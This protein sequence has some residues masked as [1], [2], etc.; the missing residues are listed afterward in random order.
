[1]SAEKPGSFLAEAIRVIP[2]RDKAL[3]LL[4]RKFP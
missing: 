2:R 4:P 3:D 1:M